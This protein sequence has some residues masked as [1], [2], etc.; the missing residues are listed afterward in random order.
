M[1]KIIY[2]LVLACVPSF[3]SAQNAIDKILASVSEN[4]LELK[5]SEADLQSQTYSIKSLNNLND[6][7]IDLDYTFGGKDIGNKWDITV[8]Q[9]FDWPGLYASRSKGNKARI[10]ALSYLTMMKRMEILLQAKQVCIDLVNINKQIVL[11]QKVYENIDNLYQLYQK[12]Y[13]HG[14]IN[15]LDINKL[16][17]ERINTNQVLTELLVQKKVVLESLKALNGNIPVDESVL[18]SLT[19]YPVAEIKSLSYYSEPISTVDPEINYG[20]KSV[21]ADKIDIKS[22]KLGWFPSFSVGYK[23]SNETG[24]SFDGFVVGVSIPLFSNRNKVKAAEAAY[25][26]K[27]LMQQNLHISKSTKINAQYSSL[28][29]LDKQINDYNGALNDTQNFDLLYKALKGGQISLL[30]YLVESKYFLDA[31]KNLL[32]I[33]Y[34]FNQQLAELEKYSLK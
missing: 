19:D 8:T 17:I 22:S 30:E 32:S 15:I 25:L 2:I 28:L 5:A 26:S 1:K 14:E 13:Q 18:S 16:K 10:S 11:Q 24:I 4:N 3:I 27:S 6:P 29:I 12:G 34:S 7:N 31:Q 23:H 21:E 20:S 9:D 33:E